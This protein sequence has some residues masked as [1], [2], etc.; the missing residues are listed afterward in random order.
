MIPASKNRI[1]VC[2]ATCNGARFV[3]EQ[4]DSILSQLLPG[5]D[6]VISDDS[7]SDSTVEIIKSINDPRILLLEGNRSRNP[8][9]NFENALL[10]ATGDIIA[11]SDQDDVWLPGKL[12]LIRS[13]F[14]RKPNPV[15]L[16]VMDAAVI[17]EN[18]NLLHDSLFE[19]FRRVGPGM[20]ANIFD[21]SYIGCS[22]A[23]SRDLLAYALP[24]PKNIPMH[25][26]WLGLVAEI[27]GKTAFVSVKTMHYRKHDSSCTDFSI[28]FTPLLQIR[29]RW[30]LIC[31]LLRRW[32]QKK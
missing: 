19:R 3:R 6:L 31:S 16:I 25:D 23:F 11:L 22:M 29:R 20:V 14:G 10:H 30:F 8:I 2:M 5:D 28:K 12:D 21:N 15:Y 17:D 4:I 27:F 9:F 26:I 24:F 1:S 18:G 32:L 13:E 7:S